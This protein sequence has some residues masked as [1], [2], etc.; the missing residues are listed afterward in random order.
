MGRE[1]LELPFLSKVL[2]VETALSIQ[3][4]P[5]KKLAEY[6]HKTKP[7]MY[8][9]DNHKPEMAYALTP[10]TAMCGFRRAD[11]IVQ[12][13]HD[14]TFL[15]ELIG[16]SECAAFEAAVKEGK[17]TKSALHRLFSAYIEA[18]AARAAS[19]IASAKQCYDAK[20]ELS[21]L[22]RWV[23]RLIDSVGAARRGD[24]RRSTLRTAACSRRSC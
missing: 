20:S 7:E 22:E 23:R 18:D 9:D 6:L 17:E 3:A 10:F 14:C 16:E 4:H 21:Y 15:R 19:V 11:V 8:K 1:K 13:L 12:H 5:D 24:L 2:S